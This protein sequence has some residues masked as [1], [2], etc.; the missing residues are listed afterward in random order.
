MPNID[1]I[2]SGSI[3]K[4]YETYLV[5]LIFEP[6]AADLKNRVGSMNVSRILEVAAGTGVVTRALATVANPPPSIVATDLNPAMLEQAAA[7]GAARPVRWQQA[8]VMALPFPDGGFD[9]VVCQFGV[10]FFPDKPKAFSEARRVLK[11]GGVFIFN[12]WDRI[13]ENEFADTVTTA[14]EAVFPE[15]PPRFLVR[16]PHGY[17]D[18]F[19]I[20]RDLS[21]GGFT[22]SPRW[23]TV[24]ARSRAESARVPAIAYCQGT[25][26]RSEIEARDRSRLREATDMAAAAI[27]ER[28]GTHAVDGKIQAHVVTVER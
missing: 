13:S 25:P 22:N 12:V 24:A 14:L 15:D 27:A 11:P 16:T 20:E 7:V 17:H 18:R 9:V 1:K 5:P 8:D 28:F 10:M 21:A 26:L 2:F 3:P 19:V 23:S 4:L 6:Y